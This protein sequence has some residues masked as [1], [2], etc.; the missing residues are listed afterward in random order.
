M[1][2]F[3]I[4]TYL[5]ASVSTTTLAFAPS[6]RTAFVRP[7]LAT[8]AVH[9]QFTLSM[10]DSD[11]YSMPDQQARFARAKKESNERYLDITTVYDPAFLKGKRVAVT[12]A[13]R[14]IGLALAKELTEAG[15][16]LVAIVR[17]TSDELEKLNPDELI[18][19]VDQTS[20]ELCVDLEHA[21]KGGPIDIV[22]WVKLVHCQVYSCFL[23]Q[24]FSCFFSLSI[25]RAILCAKKKP[26]II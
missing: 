4:A 1:V 13:N 6:S 5:F 10:S 12:G 22:S 19:G 7:F 11:R 9:N 23:T 8:S 17:S 26:W 14:G 2:H 25:T 20:N 15:A 21:I 18:K 3:R 24:P 16:K